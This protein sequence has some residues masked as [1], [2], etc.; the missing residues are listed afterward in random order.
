MTKGTLAI[1]GSGETAP[2]MTKVHRELLKRHGSE[3]RAVTIDTAYGFQ[4]NVPQMTEKLVTYFETSLHVTFTPLHFPSFEDA[5]EVDRTVFKQQVR[6]ANYVFAGPGSPSYAIHQWLP[7]H[8]NDDFNAILHRGGTLCFSSAAAATLGAFSPPIYEIY[9]VGA[10][11]YWNEGLD[12]LAPFGLRCVVIPH[13]DNNE[14]ANYDTSCC[15]LGLRRLEL[16]E[17]ELPDDV[18]TLGVDEHTALLLDLEA[19]TLRVLGRSHGYWRLNGSIRV[20]ENGSTTSLEDLRLFEAVR[21]RVVID[22]TPKR[23]ETPTD[24]AERAR[25]EGADA[26]EALAE[27]VRLSA[28]GAQGFIDPRPLVEGILAARESAR[29]TG[30][31]ALA[32]QLRDALVQSGIEVKDGPDGSTWNLKTPA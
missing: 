32:D 11:P 7:L 17:R 15:Y 5:S 4:E 2:G 16:M 31:Y 24:L 20:L 9:K 10:A 28:S 3:L 27:L 19:D 14:G 18:A 21:T 22:H 6:E 25:G 1:L 29:S 23:D 13:F 26:L 30:Q 12:V 8:L